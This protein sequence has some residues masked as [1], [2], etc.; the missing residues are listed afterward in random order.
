MLWR[1]FIWLLS[2][3][4]SKIS[5][6]LVIPLKHDIIFAKFLEILLD[7]NVSIHT[8]VD[9]AKTIWKSFEFTFFYILLKALS[10]QDVFKNALEKFSAPTF[11]VITEIKRNH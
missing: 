3:N 10:P 6:I 11:Y 9:T 8:F 5:A 1:I 2:Y 7:N 4:L